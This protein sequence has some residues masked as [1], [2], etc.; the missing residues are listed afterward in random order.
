MVE[1]IK[2][3]IRLFDAD[4]DGNKPVYYAL[5]K[6]KGISY[7][8]SNAICNK[9]NI[10]KSKKIGALS[11]E[12]LKKLEN[13]LT[14]PQIP[15]YLLNRRK[16][17]DTGNNLHILGN[18]LKFRKD[19]DI[20][21]LTAIKSYKGFRHQR[22]LPVRGQRTRAHFRKGAAIGVKKAKKGKKGRV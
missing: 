12:E 15:N 11:K 4:I 20:K 5:K 21:R 14:N 1:Q 9:L 7:S 18:K 2:Q 10:E 13:E 6:I 19:F 3:L 16:D 22:G 8:F 17:Y